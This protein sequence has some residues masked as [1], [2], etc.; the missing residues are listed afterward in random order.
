MSANDGGDPVR[1]SRSPIVK[2]EIPRGLFP[3]PCGPMGNPSGIKLGEKITFTT[4]MMLGAE[5]CAVTYHGA[6][7]RDIS[8]AGLVVHVPEDLAVTWEVRS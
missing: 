7:V 4:E 6:E 1:I 8:S 2:P 5:H 3:L